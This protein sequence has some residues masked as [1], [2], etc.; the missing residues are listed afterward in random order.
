MERDYNQ[1]EV[2]NM[3]TELT[4]EHIGKLKPDEIAW[5]TS[6]AICYELSQQDRNILAQLYDNVRDMPGE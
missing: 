4:T 6:A 1:A 3:I 5:L 2:N